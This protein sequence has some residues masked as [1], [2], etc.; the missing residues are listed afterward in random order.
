MAICR[1]LAKQD[2]LNG[3]SRL[4]YGSEPTRYLQSLE[5]AADGR[6]DIHNA[7]IIG[8]KGKTTRGASEFHEWTI[9]AK[10][11]CVSSWES[12]DEPPSHL[13]CSACHLCFPH[14][15]LH[16]MHEAASSYFQ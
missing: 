6:I 14:F 8:A 12:V 7:Q 16:F 15:P 2:K 11:I 1:F 3:R 9:S 10:G 13:Q 5:P 4:D